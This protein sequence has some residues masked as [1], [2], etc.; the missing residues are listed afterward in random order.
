M[1]GANRAIATKGVRTPGRPL[2]FDPE[3]ALDKALKVFWERGYEGASLTDLTEAMGIKRPSLYATFGNKEQLFRK[4]LDRYTAEATGYFKEALREPK[5]RAAMEKLL[6]SAAEALQQPG[7][8]QGCL[9]VQGAL[10]CGA[11]SEAVRGELQ[12]RRAAA[13]GQIRERLA[14]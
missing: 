6:M 7:Q 9:M 10:V 2:G 5:A 8:P 14:R 4:V 3:R 11:E 13:E 12:V 1:I